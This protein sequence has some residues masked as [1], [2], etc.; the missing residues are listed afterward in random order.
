[1]TTTERVPMRTLGGTVLAET[2]SAMKLL[3]MPMMVIRE[4][5]CMPRTTVKVIPRAP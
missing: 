3:T 2:I 5:A 1:M 4:T